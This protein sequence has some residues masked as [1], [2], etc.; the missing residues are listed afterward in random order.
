MEARENVPKKKDSNHNS[1]HFHFTKRRQ[2]HALAGSLYYTVFKLK[3][4]TEIGIDRSLID[5]Q[6]DREIYQNR[7]L[8]QKRILEHRVRYIIRTSNLNTY[9]YTNIALL[10]KVCKHLAHENYL[11]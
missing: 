8:C 3:N 7:I 6:E 5:S 2:K 10:K 9:I 1:S 11:P 4:K